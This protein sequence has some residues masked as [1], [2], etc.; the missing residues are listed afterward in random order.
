MMLVDQDAIS[1]A[2][3]L[4]TEAIRLQD[5]Y[6]I[7]SFILRSEILNRVILYNYNIFFRACMLTWGQTWPC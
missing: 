2:A 4:I 3:V 6:S 5:I 1:F 7:T